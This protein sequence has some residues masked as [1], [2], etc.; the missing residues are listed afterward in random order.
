MVKKL[1]IGILFGGKSAEHEVSIRSARSIVSALDK[2]KYTAVLIGID[3]SGRWFLPDKKKFMSKK[4]V[5]SF[6]ENGVGDSV[7]LLPQSCGKLINLSRKKQVIKL[8]VVFPVLHGTYGEDGTV[9]GLLEL[10]NVPYVGAGVLGSALGMDKDFMKR[11]LRDVGLP[12]GKFLV[13]H[14]NEPHPK[15]S[16]VIK[17]LGGPVFVKPANMGSSVGIGKAGSEKEFQ[18]A[19]KDAFRYDQKIIIEQFIKGREIECSVLGNE[20]PRASLP[21][22]VIP[23]HNFYSYEAKYLDENGAILKIPAD[24]PKTVIKKIQKSAIETFQVLG[25]E[26]FARVDMFLTKT[27]KI[28]INEINTIPGFTKISMYPKLW[29][30]SGMPY[31]QLLDKL[32]EL[33]QDRYNRKKRLKTSFQEDL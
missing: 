13:L 29:E 7:A 11:V 24:L 2:K 20:K 10:A 32:I 26:G 1:K 12:I 14:Q 23:Q 22:E 28:Y 18:A 33:A 6:P 4:G 17:T 21:G 15:F 27:G 25:C 8:E 31:T 19:V 3:K 9:Q 5:E 16:Q 30:A